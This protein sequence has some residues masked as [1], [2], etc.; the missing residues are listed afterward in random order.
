MNTL[1]WGGSGGGERVVEETNTHFPCWMADVRAEDD[2][3]GLGCTS[4][5]GE[6]GREVKEVTGGRE[7]EL[8]QG[9]QHSI[10]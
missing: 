1:V 9:E 5:A 3:R 7:G 6:E 2:E 10:I 4:V 8:S